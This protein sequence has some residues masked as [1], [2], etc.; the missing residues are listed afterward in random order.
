MAALAI[1]G[2]SYTLTNGYV[3][4]SEDYNDVRWKEQL[5]D[6]V[7]EMA[8]GRLYVVDVETKSKWREVQRNSDSGAIR[9]MKEILLMGAGSAGKCTFCHREECHRWRAVVSGIQVLLKHVVE[10]IRH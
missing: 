3:S 8:V 6:D 9:C 2:S 5:M 1:S 10:P 4:Y 7:K